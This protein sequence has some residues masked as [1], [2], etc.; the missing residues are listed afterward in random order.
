MIT[1]KVNLNEYTQ[2]SYIEWEM[3]RGDTYP[4]PIYLHT[5]KRLMWDNNSI[6]IDGAYSSHL[7]LLIRVR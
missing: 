4:Q 5:L 2:N 3:R 7:R 6:N 1:A